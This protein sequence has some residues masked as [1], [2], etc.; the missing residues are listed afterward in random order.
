MLR[1]RKATV[2]NADKEEEEVNTDSLDLEKEEEGH[3]SVGTLTGDIPIFTPRSSQT[4]PASSTPIPPMQAEA[5]FL[6]WSWFHFDVDGDR[7]YKI[8]T[9][10]ETSILV[11]PEG[12]GGG[13][14][15]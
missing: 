2:V 4:D 1:R 8:K 15:F 7:S 9:F 12:G 6:Q 3:I 13:K 11:F 10:L 14:D 5:S